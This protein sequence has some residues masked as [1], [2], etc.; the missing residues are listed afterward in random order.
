MFSSFIIYFLFYFG[1]SREIAMKSSG[2]I[3]MNNLWKL[4]TFCFLYFCWILLW[5]VLGTARSYDIEP[6]TVEKLVKRAI[7]W[8]YARDCCCPWCRIPRGTSL[9]NCAFFTFWGPPPGGFF[10][11]WQEK[12]VFFWAE[13][14]YLG[15]LKHARDSH[16]ISFCSRCYF[17]HE[18][19]SF[20]SRKVL[21]NSVFLNF[22]KNL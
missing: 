11:R 15:V 13:K 6:R 20:F 12:K 16:R 19:L 22:L 3:S 5:A 21:K 8:F 2:K 14:R 4:V 10:S 17:L 9:Q 1:L 7:F 18:S